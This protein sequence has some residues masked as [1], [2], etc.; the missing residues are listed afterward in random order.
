MRG[1]GSGMDEGGRSKTRMYPEVM[2]CTAPNA[3]PLV[4][5]TCKFASEVCASNPKSA[6]RLIGSPRVQVCAPVSQALSSLKSRPALAAALET[7]MSDGTL[8]S[9]VPQLEL[10]RKKHEKC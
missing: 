5:I 4:V 3:R 1:G 10:L 2:F 6:L 8:R 7:G 9:D